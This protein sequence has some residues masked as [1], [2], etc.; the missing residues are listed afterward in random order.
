MLASIQTVVNM[1]D[2]LS[3]EMCDSTP[4]KGA[5]GSRTLEEVCMVCIRTYPILLRSVQAVFDEKDKGQPSIGVTEIVRSFQIFLGQ[6]HQSSLDELVR[7]EKQAKARKKTSPTKSKESLDNIVTSNYHKRS[8]CLVRVLV[9]MVTTLNVTQPSHCEVLEGLM[10]SLLDHV[11]S[12]LA[13]LVF[14]DPKMSSKDQGGI[15]P[16]EGLSH[17]AHLNCKDAIIIA[18][19]EGPFLVQILREATAFLYENAQT[20]TDDS[21]IQFLPWNWGQVK[22]TNLCEGLRQTL[23][24]TLL[25]GVFGDDD[26]TFN[27]ALRRV[28]GNDEGG[29][30]V[31]SAGLKDTQQDPADSFIEQLWEILGWEILS[32]RRSA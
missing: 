8:G 9:N 25:R 29:E 23:Q 16:P 17:V 10:C 2:D 15:C 30:S 28:E 26:E 20:I 18:K 14:A 3:K 13:L 1:I 27:D 4:I 12:S 32:G 11:G 7:R 31:E 24:H 21:L 5:S 6:L 19:L 22:D